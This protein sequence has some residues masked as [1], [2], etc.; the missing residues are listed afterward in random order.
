MTFR[1]RRVPTPTA[2]SSQPRSSLD[3]SSCTAIDA[4]LKDIK[5]FSRR[6]RA[7]MTRQE[8]ELQIL[9]RLYYKGKNQH[10][11]AHFWKRAAEIRRYGRRLDGMKIPDVVERLRH[12]FFGDVAEQRYMGTFSSMNTS[13]RQES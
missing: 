1:F 8:D 6:L 9:E 7:G 10:R 4:V 11:S 2:L 3:Y 5:I 13:L 12:S